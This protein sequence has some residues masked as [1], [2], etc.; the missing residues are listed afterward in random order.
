M[1]GTG[2]SGHQVT[3]YTG[4]TSNYDTPFYAWK[5]LTSPLGFT[6]YPASYCGTPSGI[7][8]SHSSW[9][10]N[11]GADQQPFW[12]SATQ[13]TDDPDY[14]ICTINEIISMYT[15][16]NV[17]SSGTI[18]RYAHSYGAPTAQFSPT[19][20]IMYVSQTGNFFV[21]TSSMAN[22]SFIGQLGST[23]GAYPCVTA[24][25]CRGDVFI[26]TASSTLPV[27]DQINVTVTGVG[28]TVTSSSPTGVVCTSAHG[29]YCDYSFIS[30]TAVNLVAT[31]SIGYVF[32]GWSG[33]CS[34]G[35]ACQVVMTGTENVGATFTPSATPSGVA[36]AP[37]IF[38]EMQFPALAY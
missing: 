37:Q 29:A 12:T 8:D 28:G 31:P 21:Y 23:A 16:A 20:Q 24:S 13:G 1:C 6:K 11:Y 5:T 14:S 9:W 18:T 7:F 34:G 35:G 30:N 36:P 2:C 27:M 10:N 15:P 22:S 26:G 33:A 32:S 4:F 38:S 19:W 25:T 17:G 3:G